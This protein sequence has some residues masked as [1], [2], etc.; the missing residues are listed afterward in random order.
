MSAFKHSFFFIFTHKNNH[1]VTYFHFFVEKEFVNAVS[2][3]VTSLSYFHAK[4][5]KKNRSLTGRKRE[6]K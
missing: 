2:L 1:E 5:H 4:V 3:F 6:C